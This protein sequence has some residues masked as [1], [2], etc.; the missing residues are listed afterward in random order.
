LAITQSLTAAVAVPLG[1]AAGAGPQVRALVQKLEALLTGTQAMM[2]VRESAIKN[3]RREVPMEVRIRLSGAEAKQYFLDRQAA[4]GNA[5]STRATNQMSGR[6]HGNVD[7]TL[8][9]SNLELEKVGFNVKAALASGAGTVSLGHG[10]AVLRGTEV[11]SLSAQALAKLMQRQTAHWEKAAA[12]LRDILQGVKGGTLS[13]DG[14]IGLVGL[15]LNGLSVYGTLNDASKSMSD[16]DT[17][18]SVLDSG[19]GTLGGLSQVIQSGLSA[20]ISSR[21]GQEA[22]KNSLWVMGAGVAASAMGAFGGLAT[23]AGQF[24]KAN[25]SLA[26]GKN[27]EFVL[28]SL[29]GL[30]FFGQASTSGIQ[31]VGAFSEFMI[32]RGSQ[33][34]LWFAGARMAAGAS[35]RLAAATGLGLTGLGL[36]FLAGGLIFEV[37]VFMLTPDA[38]QKHIQNSYFGKG[39]DAKDKYKSLADENQAIQVMAEPS[40][41]PA[42]AS[43]EEAPYADP[44]TGFMI[45]Q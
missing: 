27:D 25:R 29:S 43:P 16:A 3:T 19:A 15:L 10:A 28:Y 12:A 39:G 40:K 30:S 42:A 41:K 37:G 5:P 22:A 32:A 35:A 6:N 38:L 36:V 7:I 34:T 21:A 1:G 17:F 4:G 18:F 45:P 24:V 26:G 2:M 31:F 14:H 8:R 9:T 23:A 13:L 11:V 33:R 20:A 44:M